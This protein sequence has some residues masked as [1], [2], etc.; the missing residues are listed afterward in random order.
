MSEMA[1]SFAELFEQSQMGAK[2][3][4]GAIV[5]ATVVSIGSETVVVNAG[6][7]SEGFIP[8]EQFRNE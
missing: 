6:L 2:M 4:P 3:R 5:P 8:T 7:K 1:E